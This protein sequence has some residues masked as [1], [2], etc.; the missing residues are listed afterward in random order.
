MALRQRYR[1]SST[2]GSTAE[3]VD[4]NGGGGPE[5]VGELGEDLQVVTTPK[6]TNEI[7]KISLNTLNTV[8]YNCT[9]YTKL[10]ISG[11]NKQAIREG[12]TKLA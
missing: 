10:C 12:I 1:T 4:P 2:D 7:F 8:F 5:L 6:F 9:E 11:I 3:D